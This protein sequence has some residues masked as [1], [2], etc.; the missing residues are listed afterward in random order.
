MMN[1]KINSQQSS[2]KCEHVAAT[3]CCEEEEVLFLFIGV[4]GGEW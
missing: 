4:N 3:V 2:G 1:L